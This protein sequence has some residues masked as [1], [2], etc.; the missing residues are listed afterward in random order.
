[1][2]SSFEN[3]EMMKL[4]QNSNLQEAI[5]QDWQKLKYIIWKKVMKD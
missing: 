4:P 1:M 3:F 2:I 5:Q